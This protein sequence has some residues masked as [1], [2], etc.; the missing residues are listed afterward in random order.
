MKS[1]ND[2]EMITT[3]DKLVMHLKRAGITPQKH[4]LDN[5]V[6]ENMKNHNRDHYK[7][8]L[9]LVPLDATD[10]MQQR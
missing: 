7:F 8:Q 5:E 1:K 10:T 6:S 9:E 3:Y 2:N 4:V